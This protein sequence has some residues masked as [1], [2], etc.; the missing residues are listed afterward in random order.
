MKGEAEGEGWWAARV[1]VAMDDMMDDATADM[2]T[3]E[4]SVGGYGKNC[5]NVAFPSRRN[6][7]SLKHGQCWLTA[8]S[9]E[10]MVPGLDSEIGD[11]QRPAAPRF[12]YVHGNA[13]V[14]T[15]TCPAARLA[16]CANRAAALMPRGATT[17]GP[18]ACFRQELRWTWAASQ[19]VPSIVLQ[20]EM[21][22]AALMAPPTPRSGAPSLGYRLAAR[23]RLRPGLR[24]SPL[25]GSQVR[26][27]T[28][29]GQRERS[30]Q[31]DQLV[32]RAGVRRLASAEV[33][34]T[35]ADIGS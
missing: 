12:W 32:S 24:R 33:T 35:R 25:L 18:P 15:G 16:A 26:R 14:G 5:G 34:R 1:G 7:S 10:R 21:A 20:V 3:N 8:E 22:G 17:G 29:W 4:C 19:H 2:K 13:A 27:G 23:Q 31:A 11:L 9:E 6:S 28:G 30:S